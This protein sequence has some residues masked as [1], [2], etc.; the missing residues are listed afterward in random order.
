[1][2]LS[3]FVFQTFHHLSTNLSSLSLGMTFF[4]ATLRGLPCLNF[5]LSKMEL[6]G[7]SPCHHWSTRLGLSPCLAW[8]KLLCC[9]MEALREI[10]CVR[11]LLYSNFFFPFVSFERASALVLARLRFAICLSWPFFLLFTWSHLFTLLCLQ[12]LDFTFS[13]CALCLMVGPL[14]LFV[15]MLVNF[16][17]ALDLIVGESSRSRPLLICGSWRFISFL[18]WDGWDVHL[19]I[20]AWRGLS[21]LFF[22]L[23]FA[24]TSLGLLCLCFVDLLWW[25][26]VVWPCCRPMKLPLLSTYFLLRIGWTL[27]CIRLNGL[28]VDFAS[29]PL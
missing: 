27:P 7:F 20:L 9:L 5:D 6:D 26:F 4:V 24:I 1:M 17:I 25:F 12:G 14:C 18:P 11:T 13:W 21:R 22:R 15:E 8:L 10:W 2:N 3:L 19:F 28:H 23:C 29:S 16:F